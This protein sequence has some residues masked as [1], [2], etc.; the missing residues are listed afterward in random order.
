MLAQLERYSHPYN[1]MRL[2]SPIA[3]VSMFATLS[4]T[5][6]LYDVRMGLLDTFIIKL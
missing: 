1:L 6:E 4:A 5:I 3:T 2:T